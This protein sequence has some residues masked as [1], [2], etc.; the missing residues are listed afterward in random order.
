MVMLSI[1]SQLAVGLLYSNHRTFVMRALA[2]RIRA[3]TGRE[4]SQQ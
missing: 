4:Q 3:I 2:R 1:I